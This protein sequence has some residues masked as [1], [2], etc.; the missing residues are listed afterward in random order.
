MLHTIDDLLVRVSA[1]RDIALL[2]HREKYTKGD[3]YNVDLVT[4][5]VEQI[6]SMAA[7]LAGD[8]TINPKLKHKKDIKELN[9]Y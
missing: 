7:T 1:M 8:R 3:N 4:S 9:D 5:Y 6:Q 2:A